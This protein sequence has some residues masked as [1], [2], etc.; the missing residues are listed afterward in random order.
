MPKARLLP[1]AWEWLPGFLC[2]FYTGNVTGGAMEGMDQVAGVGWKGKPL[3]CS[4]LR[5][6]RRECVA[7]A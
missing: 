5:T 7:T 2:T 3:Y 6:E 4:G 1:G